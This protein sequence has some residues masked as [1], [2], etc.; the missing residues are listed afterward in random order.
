MLL[1]HPWNPSGKP[2]FINEFRHASKSFRQ[3]I[4]CR[5]PNREASRCPLCDLQEEPTVEAKAEVQPS[6]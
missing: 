3:E 1:L 6:Q 4:E 5:L 2:L